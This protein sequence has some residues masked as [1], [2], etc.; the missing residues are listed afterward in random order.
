[1]V[2]FRHNTRRS[3]YSSRSQPWRLLLLVMTL[4]LVVLAMIEAARPKRWSWFFR[5]AGGGGAMQIDP[6]QAGGEIDNRLNLHREPRAGGPQDAG[7]DTRTGSARRPSAGARYSLGVRKDY[8]RGVEDDTVFRAA[9]HDAFFHLLELLGRTDPRRLRMA[10]EGPVSFAQ[11]YRRPRQYRGRVVP[12]QGTARR[13]SRLVAPKNDCGI[14]GYYQI[15]LQPAD[16]PTMPM[17][18]YC[19]ELP[20]G[21]PL[22]Q[23]IREPVELVGIFFKRWAYQATDTIRTTP[24]VLARSLSWQPARLTEPVTLEVRA[25]VIA[26]FGAALVAAVVVWLARAPARKRGGA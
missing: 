3:D 6:R 12:L 15:W 13:A 1:M 26:V 4:G 25:L 10:S 5:G 23:D 9:E 14:D 24:L 22:A 21:F 2:Y 18:V 16:A 20:R 7:V 19:L 8:L 11:L 17:V